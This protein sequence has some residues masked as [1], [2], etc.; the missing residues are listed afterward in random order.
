MIDIDPLEYIETFFNAVIILYIALIFLFTLKRAKKK[1]GK[2]IKDSASQ[3]FEENLE[4]YRKT[5]MNVDH[6]GDRHKMRD[7]V[8]A[9]ASN[10]WGFKA[11]K[12]DEA[13]SDEM[14]SHRNPK[15]PKRK[16]LLDDDAII[17][18]NP[19]KAPI[20]SNE[21]TANALTDG[22]PSL[23]PLSSG[24]SR[25]KQILG[26]HSSIRRTYLLTELLG[27]PVSLRD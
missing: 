7:A 23:A 17:L 5:H 10:P 8:P 25:F 6:L 2:T 22:E 16:S 24:R 4:T 14:S 18:D 27:K 1:L 19:I 12:M 13:I 9:T 26:G 21:I 11:E 20:Q 15:K 3:W